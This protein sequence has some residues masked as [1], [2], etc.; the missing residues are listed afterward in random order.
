MISGIVLVF[1][2]ALMCAEVFCRYFL[3]KPIL[4]TVEISSYMLVLFVFSGMAYTQS[5]DGHIRIDF[6]TER[7]P[8]KAQHI[9]KLIS[10]IFALLVF[11]IISWKTGNAFWRSWLLREV[12][13]GALPLPVYPIKFV[14]FSGSFLL[15]VQLAIDIY[16]QYKET[17][18]LFRSR[19]RSIS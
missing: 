8:Q 16:D 2:M 4:G 17:F 6:L 7:M 1:I 5:I 18:L 14:V 10:L 3:H 13:W 11:I 15:C 9:L 19:Q 12:R